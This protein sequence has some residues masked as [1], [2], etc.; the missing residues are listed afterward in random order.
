MH[1]HQIQ[2]EGADSRGQPSHSTERQSFWGTTGDY[3]CTLQL[4][5][6]RQQKSN[7]KSNSLLAKTSQARKE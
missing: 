1:Q 3:M 6:L 4:K 5:A 2:E 7:L